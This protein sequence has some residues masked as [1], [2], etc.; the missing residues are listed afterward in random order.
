MNRISTLILSLLITLP[1]VTR[2]QDVFLLSVGISDYPGVYSDLRLPAQDAL[3]VQQIYQQN[4]KAN[5]IILTNSL[6]RKASILS[7]ARTLFSKAKPNDIVILFFSGHGAKEGFCAYDETLR[8]EEIRRLFSSCKAKNKMIF[9]D[10]CFSGNI[11]ENSSSSPLSSNGS[12]MLF[13]SS[14]GNEE[15]LESPKYMRNGIFTACLV[16]SLKGGADVNRDRVITAREL[17]NAVSFGVRELTGNQQHPVMW[18]SFDD[19]M[20]VMVWK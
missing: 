1:T 20:P 14:R 6:A 15:S 5:A 17:F 12:V 2:A 7:E 9:A 10:T 3:A 16:R 13:L 4:S 18:G 19:K 11:R 8:Y